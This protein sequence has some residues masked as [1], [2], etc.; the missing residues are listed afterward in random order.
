MTATAIEIHGTC[1]PAFERVR[2]EFERNFAERDELGASVAV[3]VDGEP[4]VDLWA[5][6]AD[7]ERTKPWER[8]TIVVVHSVTKAL[9]S[10]CVHMLVERG[11]LEW[12]APVVRYWPEFGQA[13]KERITFRQLISHQA[14][15]PVIDVPLGPTA[16]LEWETMVHALEVQAPVWEPGDEA[17]LPRIDLGMAGGRGDPA[18]DREVAGDGAAR[19][20]VRAAWV[21]LPPGV[22]AGAG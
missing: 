13:G 22:R 20:A 12:D 14:G 16:T 15:L 3:V 18:G 8:D 11:L 9:V 4:K 5:G 17:R 10:M 6:W 21:G 2:D 19:G 1:E 7:A